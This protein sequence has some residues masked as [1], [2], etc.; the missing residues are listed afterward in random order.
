MTET[1]ANGPLQIGQIFKEKYRVLSLLGKGGHAWVYH[2]HDPFLDRHTAIKVI[3][4]PADSTRD[5]RK[6][7]QREA[8]MLLKIKSDNV[9]GFIDAGM[10]DD[11]GV[12]IVMELLRGRTLRE[13]IHHFGRLDLREALQIGVQIA[14]GVEAAHKCEVI[15]RDLK[16][17][18]VSVLDDNA[19]R[20]FDFGIGKFI[21]PGAV[22][23]QREL[24]LGTMM[25]MSPEQLQGLPAS[26]RS[27]IFALGTLLYEALS[28][29]LP[30]KIGMAEPTWNA[31]I[32]AQVD[33]SPPLLDEL[34]AGIPNFAARAIQR[35]MAKAP[36]DRYAS[37][38][39]VAAV[40]RALLE[41]LDRESAGPRP[42]TRQLWLVAP[43]TAPGTALSEQTTVERM[44]LI[45]P[46]T[47]PPVTLSTPS[48]PSGANT[49]ALSGPP[50]DMTAGTSAGRR[51]IEPG[52]ATQPMGFAAVSPTLP[53]A[54]RPSAISKTRL[55]RP[56]RDSIAKAT[57]EEREAAALS[58]SASP[59]GSGAVT[60]QKSFEA[61]AA[62]ALTPSAA[63]AASA[64]L[65]SQ[66][67]PTPR[68][69]GNHRTNQPQLGLI[70][71]S[72]V[73]W[74]ALAMGT[75]LGLT[76][77]VSGYAR[78]PRLSAAPVAEQPIVL[79]SA[80][81]LAL[82]V[83]APPA[84]STQPPESVPAPADA[85]QASEVMS[86]EPPKPLVQSPPKARVMK[87]SALP[88]AAPAGLQASTSQPKKV[89]PKPASSAPV[90][91]LWDMSDLDLPVR[92][93]STSPASPVASSS[94]RR[95]LIFG[96][97]ELLREPK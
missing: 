22:T 52:Q 72:S 59:V 38:A 81:P 25:Y 53:A 83:Q 33:R 44:T 35:M 12:F 29:Y 50:F 4:R 90:G 28:G 15:H 96:G 43:A 58:S 51:L 92:S 14:E 55:E 73:L 86:A 34:V 75:V 87:P 9:V 40:L 89:A 68:S 16:P 6:R 76:I 36:A 3:P 78:H 47:A 60:P 39:E 62:R 19:V 94:R 23:T 66:A 30:C 79:V 24:L 18:N 42:A 31:M 41:R 1:P 32:F 71:T 84:F 37:M 13:V 49:D 11:D 74:S 21:G 82:A 93:H 69:E 70:A 88:L 45:E 10:T 95:A 17:E 67:D 54:V 7:A 8:Q 2:G 26:I 91:G 46:P 48:D 57:V 97:D 64:Q 20:V 27:D 77:E 80:H 56:A 65:A 5:M 61:P 63:S 85:E